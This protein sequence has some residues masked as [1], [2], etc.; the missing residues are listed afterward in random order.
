MALTAAQKEL[1]RL[2]K[3]ANTRLK[4]LEAAGIKSPA[5]ER[6]L[7]ALDG[8]KDFNLGKNPSK[9]YEMLVKRVVKRFLKAETSTVSGYKRVEKKRREGIKQQFLDMGVTATDADIDSALKGAHTFS[10]YEEMYSIGSPIV[11][12]EF[13]QGA[14]EGLTREQIEERMRQKYKSNPNIEAR[15][16]NEGEGESGA[17]AETAYRPLTKEELK[18]AQERRGEIFEE[19][20]EMDANALFDLPEK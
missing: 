15:E 2:I 13:A 4:R 5:A 14:Q 12:A 20:E 8:V 17:S 10:Y 19:L 18:T 1:R 3:R 7:A 11:N 9:S 16:M 6:A